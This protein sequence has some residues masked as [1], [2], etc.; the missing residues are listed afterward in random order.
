MSPALSGDSRKTLR[1]LLEQPALSGGELANLSGLTPDQ[2][3]NA[4]REL[5]NAGVISATE[6]SF[7]SSQVLRVYFNLNPSARSFAR[8]AIR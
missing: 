1:V 8:F 4:T 5:L 6:P 2:L 7:D 3:C